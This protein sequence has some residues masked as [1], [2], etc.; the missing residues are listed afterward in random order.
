[1]VDAGSI[2]S[3][4]ALDAVADGAGVNFAVGDVAE[5]ATGEGAL[6][7]DA[8][9]EVCARACDVDFVCALHE[10]FE[11]GH[12]RD[13]AGVVKGAD[14]EVE[15]LEGLGAGHG[16]LGHGGGGPAEDDPFGEVDAVVED[17]LHLALGK[18]ELF[19][20]YVGSFKDIVGTANGYV[21]GHLLHTVELDLA[22][23]LILG[24]GGLSEELA[25]DAGVVEIDKGGG[26]TGASGADE[27][28]DKLVGD[29]ESL[30]EHV[31]TCL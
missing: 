5:A 28:N 17:G 6:A 15:I 22:E 26:A 2:V 29:I 7:L 1:M 8:E 16:L 13:H 21:G 20:G 24:G 12:A 11:G 9:V 30:D 18:G 23:E 10:G 3:D 14:A 27:G 4:V 19:C 31:F 25:G